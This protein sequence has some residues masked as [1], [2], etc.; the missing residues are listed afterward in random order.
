LV[1]RFFWGVA[2]TLCFSLTQLRNPFLTNPLTGYAQQM[3]GDSLKLD[4]LGVDY[5]PNAVDPAPLSFNVIDASNLP[6]TV[7]L[8]NILVSAVPLLERSPSSV[9]YTESHTVP[10][11]DQLNL[12][13][14]L[15]LGEVGSICTLFGIAPLA[16]MTGISARGYQQ[17]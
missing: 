5:L 11:D 4:G 1:F 8:L 9:L 12:L 3:S 14:N 15:M 10:A 13:S 7:G 6:S 17:D 16:S 2:P